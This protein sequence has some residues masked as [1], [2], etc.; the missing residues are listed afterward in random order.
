MPDIKALITSIVK[1]LLEYPEDFAIEVV[2]TDE[3]E[4]FHLLM[5][6]E[7][8]GRIIGRRGRVIRAIRT[9]IYSVRTQGRKRPRIVIP[10]DGYDEFDEE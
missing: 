8:I 10:E 2:D 1:P 7:D 3:F 5:N 6:P 4:E 9:I